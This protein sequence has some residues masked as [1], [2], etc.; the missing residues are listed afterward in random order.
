MKPFLLLLFIFGFIS[1]I[2]AQS[3][4]VNFKDCEYEMFFVSADVK[5]EWKMETKD[6]T[7]FL[8]EKLK[9]YKELK[10]ANGK[11]VIGILIYENGKTCCH[12][13]TNMTKSNLDPKVFKK[14]VNEMPDWKPALQKDKPIIFLNQLVL[15]IKDGEIN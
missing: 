11:I 13:F 4:P 8:N 15:N 3:L 5:P 14:A 2:N 7:S 12:S 9:D 1:S 6:M 10:K